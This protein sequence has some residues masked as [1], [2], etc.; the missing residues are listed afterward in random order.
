M[1]TRRLFFQ[2]I[3]QTSDSPLA[4]HIKKAK[5]IEEVTGFEMA[6]RGAGCFPPRIFE[7]RKKDR[8]D[9]GLRAAG[10][11]VQG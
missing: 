11:G 3:A 7:K 8:G 1:D 2:H 5:G 6:R 4:I 10:A 9:E